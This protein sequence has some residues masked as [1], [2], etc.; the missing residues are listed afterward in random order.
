VVKLGLVVVV[1]SVW[2][3]GVVE[4]RVVVMGDCVVMSGELVVVRA[5]E[6][7][8]EVAICLNLDMLLVTGLLLF[9]KCVC[10]CNNS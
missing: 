9:I 8:S 2:S 6:V 1:V 3:D 5:E 7:D 4:V 10:L